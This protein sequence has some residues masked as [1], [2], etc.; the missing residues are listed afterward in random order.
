[1]KFNEKYPPPKRTSLGPNPPFKPDPKIDLEYNLAHWPCWECKTLTGWQAWINDDI[2]Y[3][4]VCST[5][6]YTKMMGEFNGKGSVGT[7]KVDG[8]KGNVQV[9]PPQPTKD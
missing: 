2:G 1:M 6:C 9:P 8:S 5:E 3:L 4:C 7:G